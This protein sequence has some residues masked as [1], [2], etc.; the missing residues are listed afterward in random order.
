MEYNFE[1][2]W[3]FHNKFDLPRPSKPTWLD[4]ETLAYR[5]KFMEEELKEF[6]DACELKDM[7]G[8]ADALVDLAYVAMGTAVFMGI[9]WEQIWQEVQRANMAKERAP[10]AGASKRKSV[11]DVI[12]PAGWMPP[13]HIAALGKGPR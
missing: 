9:P 8:A 2:V 5:V 7:H 4:P 3:Q 13:D 10:H 6:V 1:N 11:Y 12:K